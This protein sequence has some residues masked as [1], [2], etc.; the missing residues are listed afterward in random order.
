MKLVRIYSNKNF[1]NI[2]M[3]AHFNVV[4][5]RISDMESKDDAHNLGKTSLV[6][7]INFLL[8]GN[9]NKNFFENELFRG[10]IF[11]CEIELNTG[12]FLIIRRQ[13]DSPTKISFKLNEN[14][15]NGFNI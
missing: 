2:K 12:K 13:I 5:A 11:F 15:Q 6:H 3:D 9:F 4:L 1:K 10:Q 7:V 8:L 14:K